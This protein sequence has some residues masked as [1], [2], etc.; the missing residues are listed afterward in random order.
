VLF[1]AVDVRAP[2]AKTESGEGRFAAFMQEK[3]APWTGL[4]SFEGAVPRAWKTFYA[5]AVAE[6]D[7]PVDSVDLTF[8]LASLQQ[9]LEF[10]NLVVLN[11]GPNVD[12]AKLPYTPITYAGRAADAAWRQAA[13]ARI[14]KFR[15]G[16]LAVEVVDADGQPVAGAAV[17]IEMTRHAYGFGSFLE[18]P[19]LQD[20]A[21]G[22]KYR[23]YMKSHFN[24]ATTPVYWA[25]WGWANPAAHARYLQMAAWLKA[26]DFRIRAHN[27]VWPSFRNMPSAME[28]LKNQPAQLR[29]AIR[30]HVTE[31]A[32]TMRPYD[33][34]EADVINEP[35]AE[36]QVMDIL[37]NE[38]MV[39]WFKLARAADPRVRLFVNEY[40]I[41]TNGG[42]T[43][44]EQKT[45]LDTLHFLRAH[46]APLD[47]IGL[48]GHMGSDLTPP[49]KL[50]EIL[51]RFSQEKLPI[52]ITEFTVD[53]ADEQAQADYERDFMTAVFSE[54]ATIGI[55]RWG[56][57]E[58]QIWIKSTAQVRKDWTLKPNGQ[59]YEDLVL[60]KWWTRDTATSDAAGHAGVRG[61]LGDY[62]ITAAKDGKNATVVT[63][64]TRAGTTV[65]VVIR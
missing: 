11:L 64:L 20:D 25:D 8:H 59:A 1:F 48:Q 38:E 9:T 57:W 18:G 63:T 39:E 40:S 26:N 13:D 12:T 23:A 45:Y 16:D 33:L 35:R 24:E 4:A 61:F 14:E 28:K 7:W 43:A 56:F 58:G 47:G 27:Y 17:R 34:A 51:E 10:A 44:G 55:V 2:A 52:E 54:P 60:K 53:T 5:Q 42:N 22:A 32:T 3:N 30:T 19:V 21:D 31:A 36:H 46:G 50:V 15:K 37:G 49:A 6:R 41:L 29:Q 62:R 65:R